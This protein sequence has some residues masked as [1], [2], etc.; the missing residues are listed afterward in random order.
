MIE[1]KITERSLYPTLKEHL[2]QKG[3]MSITELKSS[4]KQVDILSKKNGEDFIIEVKVGDP[5]KKLLEGISQAMRY[6]QIYKTNNIIVINYPPDIRS[7]NPQ[8][9]D[10]T[11]LNTNVKVAVFTD[12]L[13][14]IC[15]TSVFQLFDK[16]ASKIESKAS[17]EISLN[18]VIK[19]ISESIEEINKTL[20][21]ISSNEL[22]KL[23]DL[24]TGQF[25]LFLALSE[26]KEKNELKDVALDLI[27]YIITNQI[28]FY[29]IYSKKSERVPEL[30]SINSISELIAYFD[31]ITDINFKVIY[32]IDLLSLLPENDEIKESLN[33][34]IQILRLAR[35]EK[36]KHDLM[37]RLFH[38]LLPHDTRKI[39]AAFYTNPI[40]ADILAGLT[41]QKWDDTVIDPACGSGTLLVSAYQVKK[42]KKR[43]GDPQEVH[44]KFVE[45]DITGLD[46]MPFATHLT[47]V[48][49]SSQ[50]IKTTTERLKVG[51]VDSLSLS[52]KLNKCKV[53]RL[54]SFTRELQTTFHSFTHE[55]SL[56]SYTS[57]HNKGAITA[58]GKDS[59]FEIVKE[60]FDVCIANPPFSDRE[61]M[62]E[63][64]LKVLESYTNLTKIC[65]SQVN[66][67]GYFL[68]LCEYLVKPG[69]HIGFVIPINIFR[70]Q[71][72]EKIRKYFIKNYKIKYIIKAGIN[73]SFSEKAQFRDVLLIAK[74]EKPSERDKIRFVILN[75]D[76][77]NLTFQ[78][79]KNIVKYIKGESF[80]AGRNLDM[81]DYD[82]KLINENSNNL[83]PLFGL[84]NTES[85]K[86][87]GEFQSLITREMGQLLRKLKSN[88]IKEGFHASPRGISEMSFITNSFGKNRLRR[89]FLVLKKEKENLVEFYIKDCPEKLFK[90]K[91]EHL[92]P[93]LRTLTDMNR[94]DIT[95]TMDYIITKEFKGWK[96]ILK[97]SRFENKERFSYKIIRNKMKNKC[98]NM[99]TARR[100]RPN[101]RNTSLF[102][103]YSD[104]KFVAPHTFKYI[105]LE[106][107]EAKINTLCLNSILGIIN[108]VLLREQTTQAYTDIM[109][110]D[111]I[112]FDIIDTALLTKNQ[113]K[114]LLNLYNELKEYEFPSLIEQF[115]K[116]YEG[117]VKLDTEFLGILGLNR[118]LLNRI[119]PKIY[120]RIAKELKTN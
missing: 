107:T 54:S 67:W 50:S 72:T 74:K 52:K 14:E 117:R 30:K 36:I 108:L 27:S 96:I 68:A 18:S 41:I 100:F 106:G 80:T 77:H 71:A 84:S 33:K 95:D 99:V 103:F 58:D 102:A 111:L 22:E 57:S 69:G 31:I 53:Y 73:T 16:L 104:K 26:L 25:D 116:E 88:E 45:E 64:Y 28:L 34:I 56:Y 83:M 63:S 12:Y 101:S 97:L 47:A 76:L 65:G 10:E 20:R 118:E 9:L 82:Y 110:S 92:K 17:S 5:Y 13:N 62:P 98:T 8:K 48:N 119:L 70:G 6:S 109:E 24:I 75:E 35:P 114:R 49:L 79:A 44:K 43:I 55:K 29:H 59:Q 1:S 21:N 94:F 105:L 89:S 42:S 85:G 39:L 115:E 3:F 112:L 46:L 93:A 61:K 4:R 37:G 113:K 120:E 11:A 66:L 60:S 23:V 51:V 78:D 32:Q 19:V 86:I 81:I 87:L 91:K 2:E 90:I 38:D 40:A 15:E 7:C